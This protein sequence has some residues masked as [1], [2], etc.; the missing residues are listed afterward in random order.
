MIVIV[1]FTAK[2]IGWNKFEATETQKNK[3]QEQ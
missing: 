3:Q 1:T 2:S